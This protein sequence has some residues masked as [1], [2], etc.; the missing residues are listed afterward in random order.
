MIEVRT[1]QKESIVQKYPDEN[2]KVAQ[3]LRMKN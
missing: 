3:A 1:M 2:P